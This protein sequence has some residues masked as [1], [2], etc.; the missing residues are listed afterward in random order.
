MGLTAKADA[1]SL[2]GT[3]P[4]VSGVTWSSPLS[5]GHKMEG[6]SCQACH[7]A[8]N[9]GLLGVSVQMQ[10]T[11]VCAAGDL[12]T[13][14]DTAVGDSVFQNDDQILVKL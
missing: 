7:T 11:Q 10:P 1:C 4:T 2:C 8:N 14:N 12:V 5:W 3:R 13:G 6:N 9:A